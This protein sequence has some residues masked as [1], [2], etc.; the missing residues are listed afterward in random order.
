MVARLVREHSAVKCPSPAPRLGIVIRLISAPADAHRPHHELPKT[1]TID[2]LFQ[3]H[4]RRIAAV[5]LN[6]E[7]LETVAVAGLKDL[8][9]LIESESE[10]LLDHEVA[11]VANKLEN[12]VRV[13]S[14]RR[15]N[16]EEMR[17]SP[18][19]QG[20]EITIPGQV[21]FLAEGLGGVF[22][23]VEDADDLGVLD[24]SQGGNVL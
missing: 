4:D 9:E 24:P 21:V 12:V 6:H 5:L 14:R 3:L 19:N 2:R 15:Q 22:V 13:D 10:R 8:I 17:V 7:D 23:L 18:G 20:L 11:F 1:T 16:F